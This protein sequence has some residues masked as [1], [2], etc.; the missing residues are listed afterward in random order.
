MM[1]FWSEQLD[2][3]FVL[4]GA[5]FLTMGVLAATL[6]SQPRPGLDWT[7][8]ML[9]GLL[10][11]LHEWAEILALNLGDPPIFEGLRN[12]LLAASF[13]AVLE[14][15][16]RREG[17]PLLHRVG[18][19]A[20]GVVVALGVFFSGQIVGLRYLLGFP[21]CLLAAHAVWQTG[22]NAGREKAVLQLTAA[23]LLIYGFLTGTVVPDA[24]FFPANILNYDTF[25]AAMGVPVQVFRMLAI[26]GLT[27]CL[28]RLSLLRLHSDSGA[29]LSDPIPY[30]MR[31][32]LLLLA[33]VLGLGWIVTEQQGQRADQEMRRNLLTRT[34]A[35]AVSLNTERLSR[36]TGQPEQEMSREHQQVVRDLTSVKRISPDVAQLYLYAR[37]GTNLV[38]YAC[39]MTARPENYYPAGEVYVGELSEEDLT[40]FDRGT[41][42][43]R[44]P[45]HDRWGDWISAVAPVLW[46]EDGTQV[47]LALGMDLPAAEYRANIR[48]HRTLGLL[49]S[50]GLSLLVL[51][52]FARQRRF[53]LATQKLAASEAGLRSLSAELEASVQKRTAELHA[54][55]QA[56]KL[57]ANAHR[58]SELKL[59]TLTDQLPVITYTVALHPMPHTN[60]ISPQVNALLGY[61]QSEWLQDPQIWRTII[62]PDDRERVLEEVAYSN[63]HGLPF[64]LEY[65]Q[66]ARDGSVRWFR[67]T[68][69]F[70]FDGDGQPVQVHG[71]MLD[72]TDRIEAAEALRETGERYRLLFEQAPVGVFHYNRQRVVTKCNRRLADIL[73][74]TEADWVGRSLEQLGDPALL[75]GVDEALQGRPGSCDGVY[76]ATPRSATIWLSLRTAPVFDQQ[77]QPA[78]G[79]GIVEDIGERRR[80]EEER[81]KS[82]KLESLGLLAGGIAHDFN[83][84]LTS[85]L[86]NISMLRLSG[87]A[88]E[89]DNR[90]L[91]SEAERAAKRAK[92]L[93]HQLLTFAKGGSPVKSLIRVGELIQETVSFALRGSASRYELHLPDDLWAAEV[94]AGQMAQVFQNLVI[95]ADQAMPEGGTITVRASQLK[96]DAGNPVGLAAG[97]YLKIE[98]QDTGMGIPPKHLE[99]IFDPYFTT[100][101]KGSGLGLTTSFSIVTKHGGHITASSQVGQGSLFTVYLP[102]RENTVL[103]RRRTEAGAEATA[104]GQGRLLVMDDEPAI[105]DITQRMLRRAG[106]EVDTAEHGEEA[107]ALFQQARTEGRP[108]RAVILDLTI[109]GGLGGR[110]TFLRL[111]KLD[112]DLCALVASGYSDGT[113][114]ETLALGFSGVVPKPFTVAELLGAVQKVVDKPAP[115]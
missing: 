37:H 87:A 33:A 73:H 102:A 109:P 15:G 66:V 104:K 97:P 32:S 86:G 90:E 61:T 19:L 42:Y 98:V 46:S 77:G 52:F 83:N 35:V 41:A 25:L 70:Q 4:Y 110:E 76:Q 58:V 84:I 8:L 62:H 55:N 107:I 31:G 88:G 85:I 60:F 27:C 44:D 54:S 6:R 1:S 12:T 50:M 106:Y 112:P 22:H 45:Y 34:Q 48:V 9:F 26:V 96:L 99:R 78:G 36:L 49:L 94:D 115:P 40:F 16:R 14:F 59:R 28:W 43:V 51:D 21:A 74:G 23:L 79:V 91:L 82:Q 38:A 3:V 89:P 103:P 108:F 24:P 75:K 30:H 47:K 71:V 111:R 92:D 113:L 64:D 95:N 2:Q 57:E 53:W 18:L 63:R 101:S 11:G 105:R 65:R 7:W 114:A 69:R 56:L 80:L 29:N 68:A 10:H 81:T 17:Q 93:T 13:L 39:S 67:N 5:A 72:I 100:K 20:L